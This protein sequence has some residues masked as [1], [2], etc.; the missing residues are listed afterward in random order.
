M[1]PQA[2]SRQLVDADCFVA[3]PRDTKPIAVKHS[4]TFYLPAS[5]IFDF[6]P[7]TNRYAGHAKIQISQLGQLFAVA[8]AALDYDTA[9]PADLFGGRID[10]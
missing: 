6:G 8:V 9:S 4:E 2:F 3:R 7:K 5:P 10:L 1:V